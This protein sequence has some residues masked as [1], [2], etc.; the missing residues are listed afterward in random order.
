M[1][2]KLNSVR[3]HALKINDIQITE[4]TIFVITSKD[5]SVV[6]FVVN[7]SRVQ[8]LKTYK[9]VEVTTTRSDEFDSRFSHLAKFFSLF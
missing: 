3:N 4:E 6:L 1:A 7:V 5:T 2:K 8:M 9:T